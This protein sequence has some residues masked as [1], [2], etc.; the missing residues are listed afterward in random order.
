VNISHKV[1]DNHVTIQKPREGK[2]QGESRGIDGIPWKG[3]KE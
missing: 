3:E 1:K 2:Y